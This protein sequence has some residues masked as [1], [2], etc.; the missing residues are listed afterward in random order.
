MNKIRIGYSEMTAVLVILI[1]MKAFI[2]YPRM[3]TE[4]GATAGW[5][6]PIAS[7]ALA[8]GLW[9]IIARLLERFPGK[10]LTAITELLLGPGLGIAVNLIMFC[11]FLVTTGLLLRIFSESVI[12]S[13]LPE[14]PLSAIAVFYLFGAWY[15]LYYGVEAL[16]RS[17]YIA[18]VYIG[19]GLVMSL[20]ALFPYYDFRMLFPV[21]GFGF[22]SFLKSSVFEISS[23]GEVI[24]LAYLV[25]N[26]SSSDRAKIKKIGVWSMGVVILLFTSMVTVYLM[27]L[28]YPTSTETFVP[29]YQLYRSIFL[30]HYVQRVEAVFVI[31]AAFTAIMRIAIGLFVT[32]QILKDTLK[33]PYYRPLLGLFSLLLFTIAFTPQNIVETVKLESLFSM[34]YGGAITFGL[35]LLLCAIAFLGGKGEK[36]K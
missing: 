31:F 3:I 9:L 22:G 2:G 5:L 18:L 6:L 1:G 20:A 25:S 19:I 28:P 13:L 36:A 35:P 17:S 27:V 16:A 11:Y 26:F 34:Y 12:L 14:T 30:G 7:G 8:L 15:A 10:P 4:H 21:M 24:A 33:I 23:F 29:I 32:L